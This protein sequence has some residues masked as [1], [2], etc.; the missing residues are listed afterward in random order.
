MRPYRIVLT[1]PPMPA[2]REKLEPYAEMKV[3]E[4]PGAIPRGLLLEWLQDADGLF[5][6]GDVRV[7]EELLSAAPRLKA[8]SQSSVGY[9]NVDVEACTRRG[10]PFGNT[11][12]VL[13]ETTADLA[14]GLLLTAARRIHEGWEWVRSGQWREDASF[15]FGVDLYGKTLGIV[16]M[17]DIGSAVARRALASGMRVIYHNRARRSDEEA[18]RT[19]Y[20]DFGELL[21]AADFIVVL[22]PLSA[23]TQG[24]F[25]PAEFARM[26]PTAYFVNA[27]R[28]KI[29]QTEALCDA[30]REG[31]IAYAALD[32]TDPEPL[33]AGH[34]LLTLPNVLITPHIGSATRETRTRMAELAADNLIAGLHGRRLP[35]C[36]NP[37]VFGS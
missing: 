23:A 34:P 25:G 26:K 24:M 27:S 15:P 1:R 37:Q 20:A 35:A 9:D 17:G 31:R 19:A 8:I 2:A 13:V 32:V 21:A 28:G 4:G 18:L 36:V 22:V 10:I 6:L 33:P 30:L 29:V 11:P 3:W 5:S 16:G 7:D 12:G 14:F